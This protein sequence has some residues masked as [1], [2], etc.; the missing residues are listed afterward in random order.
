M[1][2]II[3]EEVEKIILKEESERILALEKR[4]MARRKNLLNSA[5]SALVIISVSAGFFG[6]VSFGRQTSSMGSDLASAIGVVSTEL[7]SV[8]AQT[9]KANAGLAALSAAPKS[10]AITEEQKRLSADVQ[11]LSA[12]MKSL[13][14]AIMENPERALS[15]PLIRTDLVA[16][17][18]RFDEYRI[19]NRTEI[20]HLYAQQQWMLG[21]IATV[22]VALFGGLVTLILN[23]LPAK[24]GNLSKLDK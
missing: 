20:D 4:E 5:I 2:G 16:Q 23:S 17:G 6:F 12:R 7:Q 14:A 15:I 24:E 3:E 13:E 22:I 9:E 21:G 18:A 8:K 1:P 10:D 11:L 19:V